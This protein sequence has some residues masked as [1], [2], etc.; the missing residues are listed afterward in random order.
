MEMPD[1]SQRERRKTAFAVQILKCFAECAHSALFLYSFWNEAN[2]CDS[3][4]LYVAF[5][6]LGKSNFFRSSAI[7][8]VHILHIFRIEITICERISFRYVCARAFVCL[9]FWTLANSFQ[10]ARCARCAHSSY[11]KFTEKSLLIF[12]R[13]SSFKCC[14]WEKWRKKNCHCAR[15]WS[16][17]YRCV[18]CGALIIVSNLWTNQRIKSKHCTHLLTCASA[19]LLCMRC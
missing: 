4:W 6:L 12:S 11:M 13:S 16:C 8:L 18:L 3:F 17:C 1:Q 9:F 2:T 10:C 14:I 15:H 19:K 5:G 7:Y